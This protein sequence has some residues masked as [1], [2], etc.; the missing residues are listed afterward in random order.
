M[1]GKA[2]NKLNTSPEDFE[3]NYVPPSAAVRDTSDRISP[4]VLNFLAPVLFIL[5]VSC[6]RYHVKVG[7]TP[8]FTDFGVCAKLYRRFSISV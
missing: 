1:P 4:Q 8:F 7:I 2:E 6:I 3:L 5:S